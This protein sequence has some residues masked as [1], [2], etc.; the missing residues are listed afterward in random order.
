MRDDRLGIH[1][2][3]KQVVVFNLTP[4]Q[5]SADAYA[6]RGLIDCVGK[7]PRRMAGATIGMGVIGPFGHAAQ[8]DTL[9]SDA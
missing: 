6:G 8:S 2:P 3:G 9:T 5:P 7:L 1:I 4:Q